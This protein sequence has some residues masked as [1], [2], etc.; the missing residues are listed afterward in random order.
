MTLPIIDI[1]D[2]ASPDPRIRQQVGKAL[3]TA[4]LDSGF[5]YC[6]GHGVPRELMQHV[7]RQTK[8]FFDQPMSTKMAIEKSQSD[9]NRGYEVLGGQTLQQGGQPDQKEGFY[10]GVEL[11][12]SDPRVIAKR[13]NRGPNLWPENMPKFQSVLSD[14]FEKMTELGANLMR[15]IALS[16]T[17]PEDHFSAY[18]VD[19][20]A[21]LRLLHYPPQTPDKPEQHGAGAHTDFGGLTILLQD[22]CGGLQVWD[23]D[24]ETWLD[25]LPLSGAFVVNLG[26]MIAR[27]T[28]DQYQSTLHRVINTS[29]RERYSVPFFYVGN[30]DFKVTC[31]ESCLAENDTPRYAPIT[32]EEHL[33][34]MYRKTYGEP[35][36]GDKTTPER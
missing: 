29:G 25:A 12:K 33:M 35:E 22:D 26:D 15:G 8:D 27:W 34:S 23:R 3:R 31:I 19:T 11:P 30:P 16:L 10:M 24:H 32:V 13:F 36:K 14:Y 5:F 4:C 18:D 2:L 6:T 1:S 28:N 17:L 7:M 20:L 21:T 9:C